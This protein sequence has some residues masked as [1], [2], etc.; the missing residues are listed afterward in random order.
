M[1][2]ILQLLYTPTLHIIIYGNININYLTESEKKN[3]LDTLLLSYN[4]TS[5]INF[6]TR[7]KN[8]SAATIDNIFINVSQFG[9][10]T[11]TPILNGLSDHDAQLLMISTDYSYMTI[12]KSK[13]VGEN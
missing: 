9:S 10:C 13:T 3:Q 6:P 2:A 7:I 5:I 4:L 8:T 11:V 12:Q 1:D